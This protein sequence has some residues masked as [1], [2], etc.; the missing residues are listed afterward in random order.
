MLE[1]IQ[2]AIIQA[3][4]AH[5]EKKSVR[6]VAILDFPQKLERMIMFIMHIPYSYVL[7]GKTSA[8]QT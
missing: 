3:F 6:M 8:R 1:T 2:F 4:T 7:C 5:W